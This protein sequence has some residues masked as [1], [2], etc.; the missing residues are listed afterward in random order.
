VV[1]LPVSMLGQPFGQLTTAQRDQVIG[2]IVTILRG[3]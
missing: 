2:R 3:S 1:W